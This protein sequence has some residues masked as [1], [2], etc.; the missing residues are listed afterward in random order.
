MPRFICF[1]AIISILISCENEIN[2]EI[3]SIEYLLNTELA[4]DYQ[5]KNVNHSTGFGKYAISFDLLFSEFE[6]NRLIDSIDTI[7]FKKI[8]FNEIEI[9]SD[10]DLSKKYSNN[11]VR[12]EIMLSFKN[13][14]LRYS[15]FEK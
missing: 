12:K 8:D 15:K 4:Y 3:K 6:F 13:R 5:I 1:L 9:K 11:Q 10:F 2:S 7:S 14:T